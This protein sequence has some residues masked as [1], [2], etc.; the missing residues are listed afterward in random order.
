CGSFSASGNVVWTIDTLAGNSSQVC[1]IRATVA[2]QPRTLTVSA[3]LSADN[4]A[5]LDQLADALL[6]AV[7]ARPKQVSV[8]AGGTATAA[9][10]THIVLNDSASRSVFQS[11][12]T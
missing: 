6:V 4:P 5:S 1:S 12:E 8:I 11:R 3:L 2:G 7:S 9:N 10:S